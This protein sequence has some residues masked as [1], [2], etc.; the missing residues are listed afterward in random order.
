M[1]DHTRLA[2]ETLN[3]V[4][5][6]AEARFA[7]SCFTRSQFS[8]G[9]RLLSPSVA[10]QVRVDYKSLIA[11]TVL[12]RAQAT[13]AQAAPSPDSVRRLTPAA[14]PKLPVTI[15]HDLERRGCLVPQPYEA[16]TPSNV[17]HGAFTV[18]KASEW[19][20]LC[21][22]R[23]TSQILIYRLPTRG[24]A[25]VVDSLQR[26]AD[27]VW[28]QGIGNSRWGF[29]R[30]LRLLPLRRIRAWRHDVEGH[31]I[32]PP[33]DHDAI[34]QAFIEKAAEA[35]YYVAGRLYRRVTAD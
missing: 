25:G 17:I 4:E 16:R 6:S 14:F 24:S 18:A 8:W 28:M 21:S 22:L 19:A 7:R 34:E 20:I 35:F 26:S 9:I 32:P 2:N 10:R 13:I 12:L 1:K 23:D 29:S 27:V 5:R 30:L 11:V 15:R 31:A 3:P 33:I